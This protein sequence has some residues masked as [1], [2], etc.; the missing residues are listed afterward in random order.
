MSGKFIIYALVDPRILEIRY[1]GLSTRG[2][3][4]PRS[5]GRPSYLRGDDSHEAE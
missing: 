2:L 4:R 1:V 3:E 5:H